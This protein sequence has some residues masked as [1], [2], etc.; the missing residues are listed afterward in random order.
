MEVLHIKLKENQK[1]FFTSDLHFNHSNVIRFCERPFA[2]EKEMNA[3][4]I[5]NWNKVVGENDIVFNLGD[6]N[7]FPA[8]HDNLKILK[9]LNGIHYL[10]PGNHDKVDKFELAE[11][12]LENFHVCN[13]V[14]TL[15]LEDDDINT[16]HFPRKIM[17]FALSHY[18]L[19]CWSHSNQYSVNLFGHIHS[20]SYKNMIEFGKPIGE[21]AGQLDVGCDAHKYTPVELSRVMFELKENGYTWNK[22]PSESESTLTPNE[23]SPRS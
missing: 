21:K 22:R 11:E 6:L 9:Q 7:W 5:A 12:K 4:L 8:N 19:L 18:P 15:Y 3:A 1:I 17:E 13:D 10:I 2:N 16:H 14:V 20:R 23:N